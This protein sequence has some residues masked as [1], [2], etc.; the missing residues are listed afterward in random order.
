[1]TAAPPT[2]A[3][4][5][6]QPRRR[7]S[8][9]VAGRPS[10]WPW[11][12]GPALVATAAWAGATGGPPAAE[13]R[14]A[15]AGAA[16]A[17]AACT[18]ADPVLATTMFA[19]GPHPSQPAVVSF[20]RRAADAIGTLAVQRDV[21]AAYG[22]AY[23][24]PK[25]HLY[26][27]AYHKRGAP[28]GPGGPGAVYRL[29]VA[30]GQV[31][32]WLTVPN[33]GADAHDAGGGHFPDTSARTAVGK[34]GLGDIDLNA[35]GSELFVMNLADKRIYRYRT[36]DGA[37]L[38][39]LPTGAAGEP[40]AADARPFA[41][42]VEGDVLY[43]GVVDAAERRQSAADLRAVVYASGHD[44]AA[45]RPVADFGLDYA[46]GLVDV[47]AGLAARW[48]PW[49]DGYVFHPGPAPGTGW[50]IRPQPILSDIVF[51]ANGDMVLGLRDRYG[52]MG[53]YDPSGLNPDG[54]G[55]MIPAGDIVH[56]R[57]V[58][59]GF[60][61]QPSPEYYTDDFGPGFGALPVH[62]ETAFG[63]LAHLDASDEVVTSAA[64]P[65]DI[66]T[67][68]ALWFAPATAV[69]T[70]RRELYRLAGGITY[71]KAN[72]LGDVEQL[73]VLPPP[74]S[75]PSVTPRATATA[76]AT[77]TPTAAPPPSATA[78]AAPTPPSM[79]VCEDTRRKVPPAVIAAAL[80]HPEQYYGWRYRLD[81]NKPAGP[82]NPERTC[83][84]VRNVHQ[85]YHP[86]FNTP[87][88]RVG[89]PLLP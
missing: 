40:W 82:T 52:D 64:A 85:R 7:R 31:A 39:T 46:R 69:N 66:V 19:R 1:M 8:R 83:L 48:Q 12:A 16:Q 62:D 59:G 61:V 33:A 86:I 2:L 51:T 24:R 42:A 29:D 49:G 68:G 37:L 20:T 67:G 45:M 9:A 75:P 25:H 80:A 47:P 14:P 15:A 55:S 6:P 78:T 23:D 4:T 65:L 58:G 63:G 79:C 35:D 41:L 36:E 84:T 32:A 71:A 73:C 11:L 18:L 3:A 72:G 87:V 21:G 5:Q 81:P 60:V 22:L 38:G 88:W 44:G 50:N 13:A 28:F 70:A 26:I 76:T 53:F 27:A 43:H 34:T 54:E 56:A 17:A 30:T 77:T 57:K 74:E 89:C 10:P